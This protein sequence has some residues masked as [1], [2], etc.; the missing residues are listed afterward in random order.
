MLSVSL[1][2]KDCNCIS[3]VKNK[4]IKNGYL[5]FTDSIVEAA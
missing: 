2:P 5:D 3:C 4:K 1:F